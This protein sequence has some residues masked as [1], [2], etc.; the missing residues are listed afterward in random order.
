MAWTGNRRAFFG[1]AGA[2]ALALGLHGGP[3]AAQTS[4][5]YPFSISLAAWSLHRRIGKN[6]ELEDML[7]LP[8]IAKEEFGITA[9]EL[10]N[11]QMRSSEPDYIA[12]LKAEAEKHGVKI[13]L[14][15][16]DGAGE[17]GHPSESR[18]E[19]ALDGHR[20]WINI[21]ATL[22]CHSIRMNWG[23]APK[24]A[25]KNP[26]EIEALVK[27][28]APEFRALCDY[29]DTK[30]INILLENHWG[31]SSYPEMVAKLV[32]AI[33]HPRFGTLPDFGNFPPEVDKYTAVDA[34]MTHAKAV[35]AKCYDF[36][37]ATGQETAIDFA[38]MLQIVCE[39]HKYS[40]YIGIEFEGDRMSESEGILAA[41]KLLDSFRA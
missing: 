12:S 22:G 36:D 26:A 24:D 10:V 35:S 11:Q 4:P 31:P 23:G 13:L 2:G 18:R 1:M 3:A 17:I 7:Q 6:P 34:L 14:I 40:G 41:K 15:M 39:K 16:V 20:Q 28:S 30:N 21:A 19:K 38:R 33:G 25:E 27:R 5:K 29:G 9:I 37:S 8:R 32:Q